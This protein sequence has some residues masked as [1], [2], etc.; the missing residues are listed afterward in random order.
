MV[1]NRH[2]PESRPELSIVIP[3]YNDEIERQRFFVGSTAFVS[4]RILRTP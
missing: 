3:A 1:P 4:V 2:V